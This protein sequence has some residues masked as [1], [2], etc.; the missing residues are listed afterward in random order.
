M[1]AENGVGGRTR[2]AICTI[3]CKSLHH[4]TVLLFLF[5]VLDTLLLFKI[6]IVLFLF[7]IIIVANSILFITYS[8]LIL[9][10][11][12]RSVGVYAEI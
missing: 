1:T 8:P 6:I 7:Q 11:C 9:T 10:L 12:F 4:P 3:S 2:A 5:V